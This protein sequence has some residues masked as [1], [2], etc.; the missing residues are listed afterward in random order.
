MEALPVELMEI[1]FKELNQM[2]NVHKCFHTC[3]FWNRIIA[4][5]YREN[6]KEGQ[7]PENRGKNRFKNILPCKFGKNSIAFIIFITHYY[8]IL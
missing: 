3:I 2:E 6:C 4:N 8:L 5:M 7:R 1:I